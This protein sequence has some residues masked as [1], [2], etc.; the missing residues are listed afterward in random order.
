[1]P[2]AIA[3]SVASLRSLVAGWRAAGE[4]VAL[5][6]T[7][8]ALHRG[9]ITL[10]EAVR[11]HCRRVVVSIFVNP[12][13]FAPG[14]DFNR[15]PRSF[16]TDCR[17]VDAAGGDA[18]F[19]PSVEEMYPAGFATEVRVAGLTETLCGPFR[20]GHFDGVATVVAKLFIQCGCDLAAFGEKDYQQLQVVRRMATDLDLPLTILGVPTVREPDGLALSSR[21]AYL[22]PAER[23]IAPRLYAIMQQAAA[24]LEA[25]ATAAGAE[26]M[27]RKALKDAGFNPV[28]YV[29]LV[30]A[31][32]LARLD[33][34]RG[35]ARLAVA[36]WLGQTR[37]IDNI[38]V[39][40][41]R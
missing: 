31:E 33:R 18:V 39:P 7:M 26:A 10:V 20:P 35:Q 15:Y 27:A 37:L 36:A 4:R 23:A 1:M 28:E 8:G 38:P 6:P 32:S 34:L 11:Q 13:Q 3:R 41:A 40:S 21:N 24:A 29:E 14:S 25:G 30:D 17:Q 22:S 12:L 19:A 5:V 16:E 2:P 9:H